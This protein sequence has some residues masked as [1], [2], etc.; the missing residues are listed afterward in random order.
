M[1]PGYRDLFTATK[2]YLSLED[3][4]ESPNLVEML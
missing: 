4:K 1:V 3:P 2:E